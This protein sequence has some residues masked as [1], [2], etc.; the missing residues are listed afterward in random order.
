M[1][2]AVKC[3]CCNNYRMVYFNSQQY[4][5]GRYN[6]SNPDQI[7]INGCMFTEKLAGVGISKSPNCDNL[8]IYL[9]ILCEN[10]IN[11]RNLILI[12]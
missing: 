6:K 7:L 3:H 4:I 5:W 1:H 8:G 9:Y 12:N 10:K 2:I 11:C